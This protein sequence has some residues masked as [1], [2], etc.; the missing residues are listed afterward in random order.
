MILSPGISHD[1]NFVQSIKS[2][3]IPIWS[4]I[5]LAFRLMEKSP[6]IIAITGTN[7]KTTTVSLL[8]EI[9]KKSGLKPFIG[10]NIGVSFCEYVLNQSDFDIICLEL[11]SFQ[12]E[13]IDKFKPDI[14]FIL[15]IS[16]NHGER[17]D[18]L[19]DYFTAKFNIQKNMD[20]TNPL[21]LHEAIMEK[22]L[23][24]SKASIIKFPPLNYIELLQKE[25]ELEHFKLQGDHNLLNLWACHLVAL[26]L[27]ISSKVVNDVLKTFKAIAH[28]IELINSSLG[29]PVYNDS[30]STNF[31]S[32]KVALNSF[33]TKVDLILGGKLRGVGDSIASHIPFLKEKCRMIYL[34][35]ESAE[36]LSR[37]LS[38]QID[39]VVCDDLK[40]VYKSLKKDKNSKIV[41]FSPGHPSFDQ[42]KNYIQRGEYF[43]KTFQ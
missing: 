37:D 7:G 33:D 21:F 6:Q 31:E 35:G 38:G 40:V 1:H 42:F 23:V 30:K 14:A 41:L 22:F 24:K 12:L 18:C 9:L 32:T 34:I 19:E 11:S 15:N 13:Q 3:G 25:Y 10:G 39:H 26:K 17:Y 36:P 28:R 27:K 5:E 29:I 4:E 2:L 20:H 16:M 43:K 8:G